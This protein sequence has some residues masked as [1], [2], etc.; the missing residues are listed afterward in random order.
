VENDWW[1]YV[2]HRDQKTGKHYVHVTLMD[3]SMPRIRVLGT[4]KSN[5]PIDYPFFQQVALM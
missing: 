4:G 2:C 3:G 1:R 5:P